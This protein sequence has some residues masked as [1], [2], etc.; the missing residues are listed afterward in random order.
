[1][2]DE[3]WSELWHGFAAD[4]QGSLKKVVN[5]DAVMSSIDNILGTRRGER[6]MLPSFGSN[7]WN[8]IFEEIDAHLADFLSY[9][10]KSSIE[11]W[12]DRPV[13]QNVSFKA[14]PDTNTVV[15]VIS[16]TIRGFDNVFQYTQK[17]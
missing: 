12:D 13:V 6:V 1:M 3:I 15:L 17:L 14:D 10:A 2:A 4:A 7:L 11:T 5:V 8:G 9:E 16:I